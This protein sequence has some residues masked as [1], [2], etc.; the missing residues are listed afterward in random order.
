MA[1][2]HLRWDESFEKSVSARK[3][4]ISPAPKRPLPERSVL[5]FWTA[6]ERRE[7]EPSGPGERAVRTLDAVGFLSCREATPHQ[8]L[9][10]REWRWK[11]LDNQKSLGTDAFTAFVES[12]FKAR[13]FKEG[14]ADETCG[15]GVRS[16]QKR[17]VATGREERSKGR[18]SRRFFALPVKSVMRSR[19]GLS[20][21]CDR[22]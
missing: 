17:N 18:V 14:V 9:L 4:A 21:C 12:D 8:E 19:D 20:S 15:K 10:K 13:A 6:R 16:R 2:S 3:F 22:I 1:S 11:H 7:S 5:W